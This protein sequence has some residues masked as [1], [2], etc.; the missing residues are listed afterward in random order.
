M[1]L[2]KKISALLSCI[3]ACSAV[4][5]ASAL[6]LVD[7][8]F[9]YEDDGCEN[10]NTHFRNSLM[11]D[12]NLRDWLLYSMSGGVAA[13]G[14]Y[15]GVKAGQSYH[16]QNMITGN[17]W[18]W[19]LSVSAKITL[20][21]ALSNIQEFRFSHVGIRL[22]K[23]IKN[24][25]ADECQFWSADECQLMFNL[26]KLFVLDFDILKS[27]TNWDSVCRDFEH[28]CWLLDKKSVQ[29]LSHVTLQELHKESDKA[30]EFMNNVLNGNVDSILN[31]DIIAE[32][33]KTSKQVVN[34]LDKV[35][36]EGWKE[37]YLNLDKIKLSENFVNGHRKNEI[38]W[39]DE[40][41][42]R[43]PKKKLEFSSSGSESLFRLE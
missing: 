38:L 22:G 32:S 20:F 24:W 9:N 7:E 1:K 31:P 21:L 19:P 33:L 11:N 37:V 39:F 4:N 42:D 26:N 6:D 13:Y 17:A 2:N 29:P 3:L 25:S 15:K 14:G 34:F 10:D 28:I 41:A 30:V 23:L 16:A 5:P 27:A 40:I 8:E 18:A 12:Y 43:N 35:G 36:L